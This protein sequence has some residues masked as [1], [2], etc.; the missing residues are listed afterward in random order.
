MRL[1]DYEPPKQVQHAGLA[2]KIVKLA[3]TGMLATVVGVIQIAGGDR[4][5]IVG[6]AGSLLVAVIMFGFIGRVVYRFRNGP[7]PEAM[8]EAEKRVRL[9]WLGVLLTLAPG[10]LYLY[11]YFAAYKF[12][13][14]VISVLG[15]PILIGGLTCIGAGL[16]P[17]RS[18]KQR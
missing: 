5:G 14:V 18:E 4:A 7:P 16:W 2:I 17:M 6:G 12:P 9:F 10:L 13:D 15:I 3:A 1:P 8:S 11:L